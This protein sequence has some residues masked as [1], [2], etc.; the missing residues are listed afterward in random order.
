M[1]KLPYPVKYKLP[2]QYL[3]VQDWNNFVND[4]LFIL[5]SGPGK[6]LEYYNNGNMSN[7]NVVK[8]KTGNFTDLKANGYQALWNLKS[9]ETH[10]F[11]YVFE[12]WLNDL[13]NAVTE[14]SD[15]FKGLSTVK[16]PA[17]PPPRIPEAWLT[18]LQLFNTKSADAN[19]KA[20]A[21]FSSSVSSKL[22][23]LLAKLKYKLYTEYLET[24]PQTIDIVGLQTSISGSVNLASLV[25]SV[26]ANYVRYALVRN[27]GNSPIQVNNGIYLMPGDTLRA[28]ITDIDVKS[29]NEITLASSQTVPIGVVVGTTA[30]TTTVTTTSTTSSSSTAPVY[31]IAIQN[32]QSD[33]TPSPFQML[34]NL[35]LEDVLSSASVSSL[36]SLLFCQDQECT[37][38]LLAWIESYTSDL[39]SVLVWVLLPD[40]IP[41]SSTTTIYMKVASTYQCPYTGMAPQLTS[42]YA[43][44][45]NAS[46]IFPYYQRWGGLSGLPNGWVYE[47][48]PTIVYDDDYTQIEPGTTED[49]WSGIQ[50]NTYTFDYP[51]AWD[52]Y[53]NMY[54]SS[55]VQTWVGTNT[56]TSGQSSYG[57]FEYGS[58]NNEVYIVNGAYLTEF[59]TGY[60]DTNA[61]KVYSMYMDGTYV[62]ALINYNSI[63]STNSG[64]SYTPQ[65]FI[66]YI[67]NESTTIPSILL[68]IYWLRTRAMPPNGVMPSVTSFTQVS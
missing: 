26:Y 51:I 38:P 41:A 42:T 43:L 34:L 24:F 54:A 18:A 35:N 66:F 2:L 67:Y 57:L 14:F 62:N 23:E 48:T 65:F 39:S 36:L 9:V 30:Q 32:S 53:G 68:T 61:N 55:T 64:T 22:P 33:P 16:I 13:Q 3:S 50:T 44:F 63:Y 17:H 19:T 20:Y 40:G 5:N 15:I 59:D 8:A 1:S 56:S 28:K 11:P 21:S 52:F 12:N 31:S 46:K 60:V 29:L 45:D 4:L 27:L 58:P 37:E 25:P 7:L 6:W 49:E 10:T 47:D